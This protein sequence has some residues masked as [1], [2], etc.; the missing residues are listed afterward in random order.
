M[1]RLIAIVAALTCASAQ[2]QVYPENSTVRDV[3][4]LYRFGAGGPRWAYTWQTKP[5]ACGRSTFPSDPAPGKSKV[6]ERLTINGASCLPAILGGSGVGA[7]VSIGVSGAWLSW[8]CPSATGAKPRIV[9]GDLAASVAAVRC[10]VSST[11]G[12]SAALAA[13]APGSA[14]DAGPR[15]VWEPEI[16]RILKGAP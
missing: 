3:P 7:E 11:V 1:R 5:F 8:W 10:F 4:G 6:C 2:A 14:V 16:A 13:C 15:A 12:P 9:A